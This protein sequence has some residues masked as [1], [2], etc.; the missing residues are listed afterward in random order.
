M[1]HGE[2]KNIHFCRATVHTFQFEEIKCFLVLNSFQLVKNSIGQRLAQPS[3]N[4][5][6][7]I[8]LNE[9][10]TFVQKRERKQ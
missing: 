2:L 4:I 7:F 10:N 3:L 5:L 1:I 8:S 6:T 9:E